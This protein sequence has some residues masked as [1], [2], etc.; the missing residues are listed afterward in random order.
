[1]TTID[2]LDID[3][4]APRLGFLIAI[5]PAKSPFLQFQWYLN[6]VQATH[7]VRAQLTKDILLK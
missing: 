6:R 7:T 5:Y 1:M 4:R 2:R 3:K